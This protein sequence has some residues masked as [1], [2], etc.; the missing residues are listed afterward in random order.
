MFDTDDASL[1]TFVA[2]YVA[3][4]LDRVVPAEVLDRTK[5][6]VLDSLIAVI[7]GSSLAP[8]AH[9]R[10]YVEARAARGE[11]TVAGSGMRTSPEMAALANGM[12]A[13][14]DETDDTNDLS[15]MHPGASTVPGTLAVAEDRD[16]SG[17]DFLKAVVVGYDVGCA[18][19]LAV[20]E[21]G[22]TLRQSVQSTHGIGQLFGAMAGAASLAGLSI[23]QLCH[24]LSYTAQQASGFSALFRD[25]EHI[26]KAFL[27]GG[28]QAHN[29]VTSVEMVSMGFTGVPDILHG[30]PS[31]FDAWGTGGDPEVLRARL[32]E[33]FEVMNCDIKRY[34]VGMP[35][36]AAAQA[37]EELMAE[38]A[39]GRDDVVSVICR[40]PAEKAHIVDDRPMPDI[41]LQYILTIMLEDGSLGFDAAHDYDRLGDPTTQAAMKMVQ[42]VHDPALDAKSAGET[43]RRAEIEL[44]LTDGRSVQHRVDPPIGSR[45]NRIDWRGME[46]KA[47]EVLAEVMPAA[48][49]DSLIDAVRNVE[50]LRSVRE[51]RPIITTAGR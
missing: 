47:H 9:A 19:P 2:R 40:L 1:T 14:A 23:E 36:Q 26:E 21:P 44:V 25:T 38:H 3:S 50:T 12:F 45:L 6:H 43:T 27:L 46:R 39:V 5:I 35:I 4:A 11:A 7:S 42:L 48:Q 22:R 34:P 24:V 15:R 20:W 17:S 13:H 10:R 49:I 18:F 41:N 31:L 28:K 8:G 30:S 32:G 33:Q 16:V 51:L 37:L 29:A